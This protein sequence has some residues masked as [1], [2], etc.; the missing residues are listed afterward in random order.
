MGLHF[1]PNLFRRGRMFFLISYAI[2]M[3]GKDQKIVGFFSIDIDGQYLSDICKTVTV[4]TSGSV[5][6][7]GTSRKVIGDTDFSR[8]A[9]QTSISDAAANDKDMASLSA[10]VESVFKSEDVVNGSGL[11]NGE[12]QFVVGKRWKPAGL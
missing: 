6:I 7:V 10:L 9:A 5:F 1:C 2:P 3:Y 8:V 12:T 4:G 11:Y